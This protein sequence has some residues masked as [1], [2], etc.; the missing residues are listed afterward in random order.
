LREKGEKPLVSCAKLAERALSRALD[1]EKRSQQF[2][3]LS[4]AGH[5]S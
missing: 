3:K 1:R 2:A 5:S 4:T